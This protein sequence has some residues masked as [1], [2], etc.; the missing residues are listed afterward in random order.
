MRKAL[1]FLHSLAACGLIG[2][3]L[4]YMI[5]LVHAPQDTA[6]TYA[7]MRH[8]I[9]ALCNYLLLPSL[10]V[11]LITGLLSMV[12]HRPFQD[13]RWVWAKALL[14]LTMFEGTLAIIGSKADYA[15]K[16]SARIAAGTAEADALET[17]LAYEWQSLGVITAVAVANFVL[18]IWRPA[19]AKRRRPETAG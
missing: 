13:Q 4:G 19:L 8:S 11:A 2:A 5:L 17:A 7:D 14:G 15:A 6:G 3:L 18:G 1:K 16:I 10:A 12:V 9:S